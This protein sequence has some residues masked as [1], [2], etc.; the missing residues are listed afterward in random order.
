[1][2]VGQNQFGLFNLEA[3]L[4]GLQHLVVKVLKNGLLQTPVLKF[5]HNVWYFSEFKIH[6]NGQTSNPNDSFC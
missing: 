2:E 4:H 5:L 1:M 6:S 3:G